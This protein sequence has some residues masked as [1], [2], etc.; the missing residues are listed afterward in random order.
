RCAGGIARR[1]RGKVLIMGRLAGAGGSPGSRSR[2]SAAAR[3]VKVS[4]RQ[5]SGATPR[6]ATRMAIRCV[7]ARVLPVP[8]PARIISGPA[9]SAASRWPGS[10]LASS[11]PPACPG[12]AGPGSGW[13]TRGPAG[14]AVA[15]AATTDSPAAAPPFA[16]AF[17]VPPASPVPPIRPASP[18]P[19]AGSAPP[20]GRASL[21]GR[22]SPV[23][24]AS[25]AGRASP[26]GSASPAGRAPPAGSAS[27]A[28][29]ASPAARAPPA[30]PA[31]S[32]VVGAP[33]G[34]SSLT[35]G[36]RMSSS[37]SSLTAGGRG[38]VEQRLLLG[39]GGRAAK[40]LLGPGQ[41]PRAEQTDH[42]VLPVVTRFLD[43]IA[44]AEPGDGLG[45]QT[46]GGAADIGGIG[47]AKNVQ[48][49]AESRDQ[50]VRVP[51]DRLAL[52]AGATDLA[53]D[54]GPPGPA[55]P[56]RPRPPPL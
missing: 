23:G 15:L 13:P 1:G 8:G 21:A 46:A 32:A 40:Q 52:T 36:G 37:D 3:R 5:A 20:A 24:S 9:A 45:D 56:G 28:G 7:S 6:S 41:F 16:P 42:A 10:R 4:A 44:V 50:A 47:I 19:P 26:A 18:A 31:A 30:G 14:S 49:R 33:S 39:R 54:L 27:S 34:D 29:R 35:A 2:I 11:D 51:G 55:D 12:A 38:H 48:L 43:H 25:S 22:A 53:H 17:P